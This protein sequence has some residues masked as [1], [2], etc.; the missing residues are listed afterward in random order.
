[1]PFD[2]TDVHI[3][4]L[5]FVPTRRVQVPVGTT[6]TWKNNGAVIH[7]ATASDGSGTPV[8]SRVEVGPRRSPSTPP[9]TFTYN[10]TPAPVDDRAGDRRLSQDTFTFAQVIRIQRDGRSVHA[11]ISTLA[12]VGAGRWGHDVPGSLSAQAAP[13]TITTQDLQTTKNGGNDWITHG[14]ALNNERYSTLNQINTSNVVAAQG[15]VDDAASA[16]A[17]APSTGSRPTRWSSTG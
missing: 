13:R 15:R 4:G 2:G 16:R 17:A 9:G 12:R 14:G 5:L 10:C 1:M 6:L 3:R 8:T 11:H 7:T